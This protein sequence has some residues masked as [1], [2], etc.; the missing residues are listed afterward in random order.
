MMRRSASRLFLSDVKEDNEKY[1]NM[2]TF[3]IFDLIY[4]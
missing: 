3:Y 4:L 2:F 1:I